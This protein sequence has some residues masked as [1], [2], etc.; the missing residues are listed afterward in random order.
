MTFFYVVILFVSAFIPGLMV[1]YFRRS[2]RF[3]M[4]LLMVFAGAYIFSITI[5][6]LIPELMTQTVNPQRVG[7][8]MLAGF[9]IQ[10]LLDSTTSGLGHSH[11]LD[12]RDPGLRYSPV[13][14]TFGLCIHALMDGSILIH[15]G[16]GGQTEYAT[17]LLIGIVLHKI[18][19]A[20]ALAGVLKMT[21]KNDRISM[22]L[23]LIFSLASPAGLLFSELFH[24][25][26]IM[27]NEGF[28]MLFAVIS[29]N[30]IYISTSVFFDSGHHRP[31]WKKTVI[32]TLMGALMAVLIDLF[33]H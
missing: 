29:G 27:S 5:I 20:I 16:A 3:D 13:I 33:H 32:I 21:I 1:I 14:L 4:H 9:F 17:G 28:L 24:K 8:L 2:L 19:A 12:D 11:M 15:P 30:F 10:I 25:L 6:H 26:D 22:I 7:L 18:P 31:A 23:L